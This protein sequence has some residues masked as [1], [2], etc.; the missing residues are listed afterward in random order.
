MKVSSDACLFGAMIDATTAT[1]ALDIGTGTGLLTLM[2][3]QKS[4]ASIDAID[5][6]LGAYAQ[7]TAN[8]ANSPFARRVR[9]I[10]ADL[11]SFQPTAPYDLIFSNPPFFHGATPTTGGA[12][13]TLARHEESMP[14]GT[15]AAFSAQHLTDGG[16]V[17][18][19]LPAQWQDWCLRQL[20]QAGLVIH[21]CR[22]VADNP[23]A[24]PH[25][26]VVQAGKTPKLLDY[27]PGSPAQEA[28]MTLFQSAEGRGLSTE[29]RSLLAPFYLRC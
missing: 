15:I 6:D 25:R 8:A 17:W 21:A 23:A 22:R 20:Q 10:F 13:R 11:Q 3:A 27:S 1:S 12:A 19:L 24:T 26:L 5:C 14:L 2:V 16:S 18:L 29:A 7:A 4:M 28:A 9:V